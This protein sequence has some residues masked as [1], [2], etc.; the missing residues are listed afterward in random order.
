MRVFSYVVAVDSGFAPNP[1]RGACTPACCKPVIRRR[2]EPG[3]LIV[4]LSPRSERGVYAMQV[5]RS[6][7]FD[8]YWRDP[9]GI[10]KRPR[11]DA[12]RAVDRRGDNIYEPLGDGD[13]RQLPSGHSAEHGGEHHAHERRD[14]GGRRVL[15]GT[16]FCDFGGHGPPL[17]RAAHRRRAESPRGPPTRWAARHRRLQR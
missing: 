13:F 16:S 5:A 8:D 3:D 4:G 7:G 11:L 10:E 9:I 17:P 6:V 1:F 2:A 12:P 15:I 14:L